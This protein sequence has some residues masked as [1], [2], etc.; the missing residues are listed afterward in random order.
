MM[1]RRCV[2]KLRIIL[3]RKADGPIPEP[4]RDTL[5]EVTTGPLGLLST[6]ETQLGIPPRDVPFTT[7][8][9]QYLGCM[10][11][12]DHPE[13]FYHASWEA[14]P[15]SVAR[16]LLQWRDQWYEAGWTGAFEAGVPPKLSD[17]AAIEVLAREAVEPNIGQRIQ[18][19][20][21]AR[22]GTAARRRSQLQSSLGRKICRSDLRAGTTVATQNNKQKKKPKMN[23]KPS[24][25]H[26]SAAFQ[27]A[28][29]DVKFGFWRAGRVKNPSF[30]AGWGSAT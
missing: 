30:L 11:Q 3:A 13:A 2:T 1:S 25:V 4:V 20:A 28:Q 5:G 10:D 6:V 7:R 23:P 17:M 29:L 9:I 27:Q 24:F 8:L 21:S 14:D 15:F 26:N 19:T 16:T 18:R 12:V 22:I